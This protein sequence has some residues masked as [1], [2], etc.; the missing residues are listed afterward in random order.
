ME[1]RGLSGSW[2]VKEDGVDRRRHT[3]RSQLLY[4]SRGHLYL[5]HVTN[6]GLSRCFRSRIRPRLLSRYL[7]VLHRAH[8]YNNF[9]SLV[10]RSSGQPPARI[11]R[12]SKTLRVQ[13][14]YAAGKQVQAVRVALAVS[15]SGG[16]AG[17]GNLCRNGAVARKLKGLRR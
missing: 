4:R 2:M 5:R 13:C 14:R 12:Q 6:G 15:G 3:L 7:V 11:R 1:A 17:F 16:R 9:F 8:G 10:G